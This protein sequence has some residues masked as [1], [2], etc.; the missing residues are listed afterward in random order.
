MTTGPEADTPNP[1]TW[2]DLRADEQ[3]LV[4]EA[5]DQGRRMDRVNSETG[6][7]GEIGGQLR[8]LQSAI[9]A[10]DDDARALLLGML[11]CSSS[12]PTSLFEDMERAVASTIA[13]YRDARG[14]RSELRYHESVRVLRQCWEERGGSVAPGQFYATSKPGGAA[15]EQGAR[16]NAFL[17]FL[18][19]CLRRLDSS[20]NTEKSSWDKARSALRNLPST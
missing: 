9:Q 14:R 15:S 6:E 2:D 18:G 16:P 5:F 4:K 20:L 12:V 10:C 13:L 3:T 8:R 19:L 11:Q 7:D 1:I 17:R